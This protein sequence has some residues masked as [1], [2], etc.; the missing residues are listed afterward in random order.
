MELLSLDNLNIEQ[1][2]GEFVHGD[3]LDV[4]INTSLTLI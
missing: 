2:D 1:E 4:F 3:V